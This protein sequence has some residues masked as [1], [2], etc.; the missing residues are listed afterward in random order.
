LYGI[1]VADVLADDVNGDLVDRI[2]DAGWTR[3]SHCC[4]RR[5]GL[6]QVQVLEHDAI[7]PSAASTTG[8]S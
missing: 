3:S 1:F 2:L 4:I 6:R 7:E 5:S 8:T